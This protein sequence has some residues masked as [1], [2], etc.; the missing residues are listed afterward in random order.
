MNVQDIKQALN[1]N[2]DLVTIEQ[3]TTSFIVRQKAYIPKPVWMEVHAV[4]LRFGGKYFSEDN[5][6]HWK[7]PLVKQ[8]MF[9]AEPTHECLILDLEDLV[10]QGYRKLTVKWEK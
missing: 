4:M 9:I 3:T 10:K 2:A 8:D 1:K 6:K 7:I 5:D